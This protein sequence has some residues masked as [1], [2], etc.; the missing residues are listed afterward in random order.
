MDVLEGTWE[1]RAGGPEMIRLLQPPRPGC[2]ADRSP[3]RSILA[4]SE[5]SRTDWGLRVAQRVMDLTGRGE[6]S[7]LQIEAIPPS[8]LLISL[9]AYLVPN[10]H[11]TL[12]SG[13]RWFEQV[14]TRASRELLRA[15]ERIGEASGKAW[16]NWRRQ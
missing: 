3:D 15:I 14:R 5:K 11:A 8:E 12:E 16:A 6:S 13:P 10:D 7:T 2:H 9:S 1:T 4:V